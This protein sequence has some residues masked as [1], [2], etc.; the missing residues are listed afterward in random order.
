MNLADLEQAYRDTV[1]L[2][3]PTSEGITLYRDK[4]SR[5][6]RGIA[7]ISQNF[8]LG[9]YF[10]SNSVRE[11]RDTVDMYLT[12]YNDMVLGS[13]VADRSESP[14]WITGTYLAIHPHPDYNH[15]MT[16]TLVDTYLAHKGLPLVNWRGIKRD[17]RS[18]RAYQEAIDQY[19]FRGDTKPLAD[20]FQKNKV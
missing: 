5:I 20:Q 2:V 14:T 1:K 13:R 8:R 19:I 16:R 12:W 3:R 11:F 10:G 7:E 18:R 4:Q 6:D 9:F 17:E 15:T